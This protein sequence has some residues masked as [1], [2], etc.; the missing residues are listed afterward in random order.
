[1]SREL[2]SVILVMMMMMRVTEQASVV[3]MMSLT[4]TV[5]T[6][7]IPAATATEIDVHL[8]NEDCVY[9]AALAA[10]VK[11]THGNDAAAMRL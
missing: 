1:M 6:A 8:L 3:V 4:P 9:A 11:T 5:P 7:D 2:R 10:L